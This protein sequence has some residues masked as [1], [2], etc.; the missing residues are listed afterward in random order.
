MKAN[1]ILETL[2]AC[3]VQ[4][5][6][7]AGAHSSKSVVQRVNLVE[8]ILDQIMKERR[9]GREGARHAKWLQDFW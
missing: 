3:S 5:N 4:E 8:K 9:E 7:L 1:N 2:F 6:N